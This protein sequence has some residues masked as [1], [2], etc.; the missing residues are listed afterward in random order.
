M[1]NTGLPGVD[2]NGGFFYMR[3]CKTHFI[4]IVKSIVRF[5]NTRDCN[6]YK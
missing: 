3:M 1:Y 4:Q 5:C 2:T 6:S